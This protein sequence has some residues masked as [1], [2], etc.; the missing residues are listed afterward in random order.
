V[1]RGVVRHLHATQCQKMGS[2]SRSLSGENCK[3]EEDT[4]MVH[5]PPPIDDQLNLLPLLERSLILSFSQLDE[6]YRPQSLSQHMQHL[7][8]LHSILDSPD[9]A[10]VGRL[11]SSLGEETRVQQL[12]LEHLA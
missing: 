5:P 7:V 8:H 10:G 6:M 1:L 2:A 9:R 11:S 12:N 4:Y 3:R